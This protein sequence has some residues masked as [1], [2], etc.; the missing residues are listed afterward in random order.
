MPN[1]TIGKIAGYIEELAPLAWAESWDNVGLQVGDPARPA[2]RILVALELTGGVV[3]EAIAARADLI[4]VHHPAIFKPWKAIRFDTPG[5]QRVERLVKAGIGLYAAHTNL[6]Q[7]LGGTN[8][9]LAALAGLSHHEVLMPLGEE[10]YVKLVV[11]VPKG[12]EDAVRAALARAGAG[13]IGNYSHCTFQTPGTGT[14]LPLDGTRPF[15]GQQGRLEYAEELRLETIIPESGVR[16][17]VQAMIGAH[18]YEEV[19]YDLYPLANPGRSRGHGRIGRLAAPVTLEELVG[20]LKH[21][22]G[23]PHLRVVGDLG[24]QVQ[25]IAVGAGSG[26]MLIP[27]AAGRGADVLITG[28]VDYHDAQDAADAGLAVID[29]GHYNSE[30]IVV[31]PLARYLREKLA[32][33]GLEAEVLEAQA[34]RDPFLFV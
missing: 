14:F 24:R 34:G 3:E 10:K 9:T 8:D 7:A 17:A 19:A 26:G 11:F 30:V 22:L 12:H 25:Q 21:A 29:V 20:R 18:P 5:G 31:P 23:I 15:I 2:S 33:D 4:V 1:G 27:V 16:K 28:D 6:D 32:Q 13:H